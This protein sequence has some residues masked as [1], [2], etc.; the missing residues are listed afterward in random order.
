MFTTHR[1]L[2]DISRLPP[3]DHHVIALSTERETLVLDVKAMEN[4]APAKPGGTFDIEAQQN[5]EYPFLSYE[6]KSG[7]FALS[8]PSAHFGDADSRKYYNTAQDLLTAV[9]TQ[10]VT[11]GG[12]GLTL[13]GP[14]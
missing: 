4:L 14:L 1:P 5:P 3:F 13:P 11:V 8:K 6:A 12:W 10:Y 9:T 7:A 2:S